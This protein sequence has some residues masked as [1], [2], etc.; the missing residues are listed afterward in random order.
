MKALKASLTEVCRRVSV[1]ESTPIYDVESC[2]G[3]LQIDAKVVADTISHIILGV[4]PV[5][6]SGVVVGAVHECTD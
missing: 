4:E 1:R 2:K 6:D 3:S 5:V